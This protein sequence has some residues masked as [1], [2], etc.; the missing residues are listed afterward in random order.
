VDAGGVG[1]CG[2]EFVVGLAAAGKVELEPPGATRTI[3]VGRTLEPAARSSALATRVTWPALR[4]FSLRQHRSER[5]S[6]QRSWSFDK[7]DES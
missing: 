1:Y 5:G 2:H 7:T 6:R 3:S 4:P